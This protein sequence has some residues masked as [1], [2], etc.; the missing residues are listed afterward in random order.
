MPKGT[1]YTTDSKNV[2]AVCVRH[3]DGNGPE[4][5]F[6]KVK[7]QHQAHGG[8]YLDLSLVS[9]RVP[10]NVHDTE[11]FNVCSA[12]GTMLPAVLHTQRIGDL[13]RGGS[14]NDCFV[15][16]V[17]DDPRTMTLDQYCR[18]LRERGVNEYFTSRVGTLYVPG[19]TKEADAARGRAEKAFRIEF[20]DT[21]TEEFLTEVER[22][23]V[24]WRR[25]LQKRARS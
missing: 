18:H 14:A 22:F 4:F 23:V 21:F 1:L 12:D 9:S 10:Y 19:N 20:E 17:P 7:R 5:V 2:V 11:V 8:V 25:R 15:D 6:A 13:V 16:P 24:G 3:H